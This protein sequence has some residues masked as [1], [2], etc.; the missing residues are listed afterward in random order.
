MNGTGNRK[1]TLGRGRPFHTKKRD[2]EGAVPTRSTS[3]HTSSSLVL[4]APVGR[5]RA[6][7]N[8]AHYLLD[9]MRTCK[10]LQELSDPSKKK[11]RGCFESVGNATHSFHGDDAVGFGPGYMVVADGVSGTMK[12]SGVLARYLVAETLTALSKLRKRARETPACAADFS[13]SMHSA[14][15][16]A[17]KMTK[18]KGRLD[19]TLSAVFFDES[20]RKMFVYTIGDCKCVVFRGGA[21]VF[22]SDSIIYDFN[23]PA[24]VSSNQTINYAAE[25]E[26]QTFS[27]ETGDVCLLFSDGVHDNL[28]VDDIVAC[29]ASTVDST[30]G[31]SK[32]S[33]AEE[34]ARRI[35]QRAK[36]TFSSNTG[37]IPFAVSAAGFCLEALGEL[38][39]NQSVESEEFEKFRQKCEAI[40]SLEM[41]RAAFSNE[42]RVRQLAFYS[43]SNL[44]AFAHKKQGKRDDVSVCAAVLA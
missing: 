16:S 31:R 39:S 44:L 30:S 27:Y 6:A 19:S 14:I 10:S 25:V 26:I 5:R 28:F 11:I 2:Q 13:Q 4:S 32:S 24:V 43:A 29:V 42:Q 35:V 40:P 38:E 21:L 18:R 12:A 41:K 9:R 17:R 1:E 20:T 33:A 7:M 36:D 3:A 8:A 34:M 15:K 23:V 22:E 37:Y